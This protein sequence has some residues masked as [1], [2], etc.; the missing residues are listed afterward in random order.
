MCSQQSQY[1]RCVFGWKKANRTATKAIQGKREMHK[2]CPIQTHFK[3]SHQYVLNCHSEAV[4]VIWKNTC[5]NAICCCCCYFVFHVGCICRVIRMLECADIAT[6]RFVSVC[7][8]RIDICS[9]DLF[10]LCHA[11]EWYCIGCCSVRFVIFVDET[12]VERLHFTLSLIHCIKPQS[13]HR[14]LITCT[15]APWFSQLKKN[16]QKKAVS[17]Q[18]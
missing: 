3:W 10:V 1:F 15:T 17:A 6:W 4:C 18:K 11:F 2:E 16:Y 9:I 5:S 14:A 12:F 7:S 13:L 8:Q